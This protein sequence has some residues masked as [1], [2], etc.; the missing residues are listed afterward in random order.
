[1]RASDRAGG[2]LVLISA[3][4]RSTF[5]CNY[6]HCILPER[7]LEDIHYSQS[8]PSPYSPFK[9]A[10]GK[11]SNPMDA[12]SKWSMFQS[13]PSA[14]ASCV[15]IRKGAACQR[16]K[17]GEASLEA[18]FLPGSTSLPSRQNKETRTKAREVATLK[19]D[20]GPL[21]AE[22]RKLAAAGK[23]KEQP[24]HRCVSSF[25]SSSPQI[26]QSRWIR[27]DKPVSPSYVRKLQGLKRQRKNTSRPTRNTGNSCM[28]T[29]KLVNRQGRPRMHHRVRRE[30]DLRTISMAG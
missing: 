15:P 25:G 2:F 20:I 9:M 21:E 14:Q 12:Y 7:S 5:N 3:N 29:R 28:L 19:K 13:V 18:V 22:V 8:T 24:S 30:M 23:A 10:K 4:S 1:M 11:S 17:K 27:M 6:I 26:R 16:A